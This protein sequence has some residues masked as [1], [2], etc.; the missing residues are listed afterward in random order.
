[1]YSWTDT[2]PD[3]PHI[4][5]DQVTDF[6]LT[7]AGAQNPR[8]ADDTWWSV[9][10]VLSDTSID[11]FEAAAVDF[12]SDLLIPVAYDTADRAPVRRQQPVAIYARKRLIDEMNR[13]DNALH[14]VALHLGAITPEDHLDFDATSPDLSEIP[15]S[16]ETTVMAVI[17]DGIAIAHDLL[18][19]GPVSTRVQ[20]A[21]ILAAEPVFGA[22]ASVGRALE[23]HEI[24]AYLQAATHNDL[25]D[26]DRFYRDVGIVNWTAD[27]ISTVAMRASHGTYVTA[28]AAGELMDQGC[29]DRPVICVALP[30][31]VVEDTTGLD[32][33]PTLYLSLHILTKQARRF[34]STD[35]PLAP[36]VFNFSFGNS[37]G[38]HDGTGLFA[39]LF[40]HYFGAQA[41]L[42]D[43]PQTAWLTLPAGN[44]NLGRLHGV[45]AYETTRFDLT[46]Q[47]DDRTP[48]V[49]Q[50]W[51]PTGT[52]TTPVP[53]AEVRVQ[54]PSGQSAAISSVPGQSATLVND[55]GVEI[56]RLACQVGAGDTDRNLITLSMVPTAT[57][58]G[59]APVA[60]AGTWALDV[61]GGDQGTIHL[62]IRRDE[63]LPGTRS[64][65]RQAWFSNDDYVR[66]GRFGAPLP[67][68][69]PGTTSPVRRAGSLSG[70]AGGASP[71]V[72]AAF[73]ER[74]AEV[75]PY[76][77][78]G[79]LVERDRP[80]TP[81]RDGPDL[82]AL[83]DDSYAMRG[84]IGAGS[85]S[86]SW[87]RL[88]GTSVAAPRVARKAADD[89][90]DWTGPARGWSNAAAAQ[91]PFHLRGHPSPE[92]AGA[93]G[94][95]IPVP[96]ALRDDDV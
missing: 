78:A 31:R 33:L 50:V 20:H 83:G 58:D 91:D 21:T 27:N 74:N 54:T 76:S 51:M 66:F 26:E 72:V 81:Q 84:V 14:V 64:G 24:D 11:L 96:W 92:R 1:M 13:T 88:S 38:P 95:T 65:G 94:I 5:L 22:H 53:L 4:L 93:G 79:P 18:R 16:P 71:V 2:T 67:V 9:L 63:T 55:A 42:R 41:E 44:I 59:A 34:R 45:A 43:E 80:P 86:G 39:T 82:T 19:K 15:V 68:D 61:T 75:S 3:T 56:A 87:V 36:V 85:R 73:T 29:T 7:L 47:P 57:Q 8:I 32:S 10:I 89:I 90:R 6:R 77:A 35:G 48:T 12:A 17:D 37:G 69:P 23:A 49:V 28:M 25:L 70:F 60:P 40:E 52:E 62:W 30:Q 46:T